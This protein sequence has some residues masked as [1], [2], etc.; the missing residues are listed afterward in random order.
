MRR[1][2]VGWRPGLCVLLTLVTLT[3]KASAPH[4]GLTAVP[5]HVVMSCRAKSPTPTRLLWVALLAMPAFS[6]ACVAA[7]PLP[8]RRCGFLNSCGR[9]IARDDC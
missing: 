7:L 8:S 2:G 5:V 1:W 9:N 6:G 4:L 3:Y